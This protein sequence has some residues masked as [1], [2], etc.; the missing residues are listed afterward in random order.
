MEQSGIY[1]EYYTGR[2]LYTVPYF[3]EK[4]KCF[5]ILTLKLQKMQVFVNYGTPTGTFMYT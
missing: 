1:Q 2:F 5:F 3:S 4:M